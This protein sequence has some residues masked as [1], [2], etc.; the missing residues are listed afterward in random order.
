[1]GTA[2][3][4]GSQE[5]HEH[6]GDGGRDID[7]GLQ[8]GLPAAF[9]GQGSSANSRSLAGLWL[10]VPCATQV[11]GGG[12]HKAKWKRRRREWRTDRSLPLAPRGDVATTRMGPGG[13]QS[14]RGSRSAW[15][16]MQED[17]SCC[18]FFSVFFILCDCVHLDHL[19]VGHRRRA[20]S[21]SLLSM[22][23]TLS[24]EAL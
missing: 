16:Q 6:A 14:R 12:V 18:L 3:S 13:R 5:G 8:Q 4:M 21:S 22:G 7:A 10:C 24:Y 2:P 1:M 19:P 9:A 15:R 23:P 17:S 11:D 20:G